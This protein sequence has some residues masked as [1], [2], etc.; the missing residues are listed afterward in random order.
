MTVHLVKGADPMLRNRVVDELVAELLDGEDRSLALEDFT[1]P[2]RASGDDAPAAGGAE[3]RELV[4]GQVVNAAASPPFMTAHRVVVV[5]DIG[6]L[7]AGDAEPLVAFLADPLDSTLL[8]LVQGGGTIPPGLAK[9]L[10]AIKALERAPESEKTQDV[11]GAALRKAGLRLR[12]D[13]AKRVASH[14]GDDAGRVDALVAVLAEAHPHGAQLSEADVT[15]YLGDVGAVPVYQLT[16]A[17]EAGD[18]AGALEVLHRL[19]TASSPQQPKPMH[20]LQ[21]MG[22]LTNSYRRVLRCDDPSVRTADDAIAAIG[23]RISAFPA[24]KAMEQARA[25][26][27]DGIRQAFDHL[28]QADLDLKGARAIPEDAVME[29]LVVRLCRLASG[30]ARRVPVGGGRRR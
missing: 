15:P 29:L 8:V 28:A 25:L 19:M 18:A 20:P 5:R 21:I 23:G 4:I 11:L 2:G 30:S 1:I 12:P 7:T 27:S 3:A 16:N 10:K 17:I 14:L 26:G 9:Q 13:A 24:R 22:T 6:A